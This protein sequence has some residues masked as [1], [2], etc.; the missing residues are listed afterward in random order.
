MSGPQIRLGGIDRGPFAVLVLGGAPLAAVMLGRIP[1]W[2]IALTASFSVAMV[3]VRV[4]ERTPVRWCLDWG[5]Y[6]VGR[7]SRARELNAPTDIRDFETTNGICG[8]QFGDPILVAMIQLAPDLDLPTVIADRTVYTE[9]KVAVNA[10]LPMLE[11]YGIEFDIDIVTTG[12]RAR[13]SSGYSMLY[14]QL[15]G[16]QPVVG[17]RLTWLVVR[18]D[19]EHNLARLTRRGSCAAAAPRALAAAAY[20]IATRLRAYGVA[21][22]VLPAAAMR[23]ALRM[24]HAGVELSDLRE[25]WTRLEST[26]PGRGVSSF[27]VDWSRLG[28][29][30]LDDCWSWDR[31]RTT[32]VISLSGRAAGPRGLVRFI[33]PT[34]DE[35]PP[36]F[37]RPLV[38]R[39]SAALLATLPSTA[40]A[41]DL[42]TA[43][44]LDTAPAD[45]MSQLAVPIGPNGQILGVISGQP[46]HTFALPLFDPT[47]YN[48]QRR[49][50]DIRAELPVAQQIILR[51]VVVGADVVIHSARPDR[52]RQLVAA[53]GDPDSLRLA[54]G[55]G[56][57]SEDVAVTPNATI[58]VYDQLP[59]GRS[60][61]PTTLTINEP[62]EPR[63]RAV[64]LAIEQVDAH[65][66]DIGIPMRTVRVDLIEPRGETRYF[67]PINTAAVNGERHR[68]PSLPAPP[69][70]PTAGF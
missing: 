43:P 69:S 24:L 20:R 35:T 28:A 2:G 59:P 21:A 5:R 67:E 27:A 32:V 55:P 29:G 17:D 53:V 65:T 19:Q 33:G 42:P 4:G 52:W 40:S 22:H 25:T 30:G 9:D 41:R 66:V 15:I 56:E 8:I 34:V 39:Q 49:S 51:A 48:P 6:R 31:G 12:R 38:G 3:V 36:V 46:M 11:Q 13:A 54:P 16:S 61:A 63:S 62:G 18:M 37:L 57:A 50:V 68:P 60:D 14:D 64:D 23:D 47:R 10:L 44:G 26:N 1:W 70:V 7:G 45:V 58:A